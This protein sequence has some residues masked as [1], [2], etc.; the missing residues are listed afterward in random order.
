MKQL[1]VLLLTSL[2][3]FPA[4]AI[5]ETGF[6]AVFS[7]VVLPKVKSLLVRSTFDSFDGARISYALLKTPHARATVVVSPGRTE[8]ITGF[9][10]TIYDL[11][12]RGYAVAIIDQRGQGHSQRFVPNSDVGYVEHFED[13]ERDFTIFVDEYVRP[14]MPGPYLLLA[15][16]MGAAIAT[17]YLEND[18]SGMFSGAVLA[19]PMYR[20]VTKPFPEPVAW[21]LVYSLIGLGRGMDYAPTAHGF[22]YDQKFEDNHFTHSRARFY[23][24]ISLVRADPQIAVGGPS[25]RWVKEAMRGTIS[26]RGGAAHV[27]TPLLVLRAGR[28]TYVRTDAESGFCAQAPSCELVEYPEAYHC[29]LIE[30]DR[31]RDDVFARLNSFFTR[32][33]VRR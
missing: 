20:I 18:S 25:V 9:T 23:A 12:R 22:D 14:Q 32:T 17:S 19:S 5:S 11:Y 33:L 8:S 15:D 21:A 30:T 10:E 16:S 7:R 1:L 24:D 4:L 29:L 26:I 6:D 13:Y 28:D 2:V 3:G 27:K 31:V